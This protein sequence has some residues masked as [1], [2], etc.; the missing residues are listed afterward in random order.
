MHNAIYKVDPNAD[1]T[2]DDADGDANDEAAMLRKLLQQ[3]AEVQASLKEMKTGI[4][5]AKD[6]KSG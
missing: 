5:T 6:I 3:M 4:S 2:V 1:G